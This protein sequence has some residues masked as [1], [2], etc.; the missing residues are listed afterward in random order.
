LWYYVYYIELKI[1]LMVINA[2]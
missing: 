1:F 2:D